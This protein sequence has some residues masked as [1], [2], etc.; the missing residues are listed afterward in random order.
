MKKKKNF[1]ITKNKLPSHKN[2]NINNTSFSSKNTNMI[3]NNNPNSL[4]S[5]KTK[6]PQK[7]QKVVKKNSLNSNNSGTSINEHNSASSFHYQPS[8]NN[9]IHSNKN[10]M[11]NENKLENKKKKL[12]N[13]Y[14]IILLIRI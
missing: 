13:Q 9:E 1:K 5:T 12:I 8:L 11:K 10:K 2:K 7:I 3:I 4:K 14:L 6:F